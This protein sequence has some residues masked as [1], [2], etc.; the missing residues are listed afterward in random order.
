MG[1]PQSNWNEDVVLDPD[2]LRGF[3]GGDRDFEAQILAVFA[4]KAPGYLADLS[5]A[6]ET[7]WRSNAHKLKG[8]ARSIGAWRLAREAERA[9]HQDGIHEDDTLKTRVLQELDSRL[10]QLLDTIK[11]R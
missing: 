4:D 10:Q 2:H 5:S 11:N 6:G 1:A 3:S 9:E 8:A 7:D